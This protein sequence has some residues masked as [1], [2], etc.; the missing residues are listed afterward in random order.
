MDKA[1]AQAFNQILRYMSVL[2]YDPA[3]VDEVSEKLYNIIRSAYDVNL[4]SDQFKT[5]VNSQI[6]KTYKELV[7]EDPLR[8]ST[9]LTLAD[10]TALQSPENA[11]YPEVKQAVVDYIRTAYLENGAAIGNSPKELQAFMDALGEQLDLEKWRVRAIIDTTV[12][13]ARVYGQLNGMRQAGVKS[14]EVAGPNDSL[15][16]DYCKE[17]LGRRFDLA[18]ELTRLEEVISAGPEAMQMVKPF[19]KG[20]M[21]IEALQD[22]SDDEVQALGFACPPYHP[23]CRHRLVAFDFYEDPT[24]I[25]YSVEAA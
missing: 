17:M 23:Q 5:L 2:A 24:E 18:V 19:L 12:S 11:H 13:K 7:A 8:A 21:Q 14:F 20:R 3:L 22:A 1:E 15:T 6:N 10:R 9:N 16:C 4:S 25:P